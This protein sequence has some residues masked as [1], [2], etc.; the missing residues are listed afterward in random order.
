MCPFYTSDRII[1]G[2]GVFNLSF[3]LLRLTSLVYFL[4]T[5]I[6]K[7]IILLNYK[8]TQIFLSKKFKELEIREIKTIFPCM[9]ELK[10]RTLAS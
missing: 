9:S 10:G 1:S 7:G 3:I 4:Y 6:I 2:N 5:R 8:K